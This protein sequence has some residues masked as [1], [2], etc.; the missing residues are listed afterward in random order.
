MACQYYI[1]RDDHPCFFY[2]EKIDLDDIHPNS[3][4]YNEMHIITSYCAYRD[5]DIDEKDCILCHDSMTRSEVISK[6]KNKFYNS[7]THIKGE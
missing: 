7:G 1:I 3:N 6:L 2:R 5:D 4:G